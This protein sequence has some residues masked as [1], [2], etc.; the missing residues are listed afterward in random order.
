MKIRSLQHVGIQTS[1]DCWARLACACFISFPGFEARRWGSDRLSC[2]S[3]SSAGTNID[4]WE[5]IGRPSLREN[6]GTMWYSFN[7]W[8]QAAREAILCFRAVTSIEWGEWARGRLGERSPAALSG[9]IRSLPSSWKISAAF[10]QMPSEA[11]FSDHS[12]SLQ[13]LPELRG[14]WLS[15]TLIQN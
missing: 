15:R 12:G 13:H 5:M 7:H 1:L 10:I 8:N 14:T 9:L 11:T 4:S 6:C 2:S 3:R